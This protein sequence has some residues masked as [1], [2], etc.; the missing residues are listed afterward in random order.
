MTVLPV[1]VTVVPART[2]KLVAVPSPGAV[3]AKALLGIAISAATAAARA[4]NALAELRDPL[5]L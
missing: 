3:D 4:T 1:L 5:R 2:A